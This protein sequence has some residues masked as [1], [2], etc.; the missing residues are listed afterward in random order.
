MVSPFIY[1]FFSLNS[2]SCP[3]LELLVSVVVMIQA[4]HAQRYFH[5]P[6]NELDWA[7]AEDVPIYHLRV[8]SWSP[9]KE[10]LWPLTFWTLTPWFLAMHTPDLC[11][12][13]LSLNLKLSM[14]MS[15][16]APKVLPLW[17]HGIPEQ[18]SPCFICSR[19]TLLWKLYLM[20]V[21][22]LSPLFSLLA[23]LVLALCGPIQFGYSKMN[24]AASMRWRAA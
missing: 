21:I 2:A 7:C 11:T 23:E 4:E 16:P 6:L 10:L 1:L 14:L 20:Q 22:N 18:K 13:F 17:L 5:G 8:T 3:C 15:V 19:R 12:S 24:G 9:N